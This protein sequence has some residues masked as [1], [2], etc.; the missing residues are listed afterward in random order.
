MMA[1]L[2]SLARLGADTRGAVLIETAIVMPVLV[3]MCLGA[4]EVSMMV[5]RQSELQGAAAEAAAIA[6]AAKP[7]T[8]EKID[9]VKQV[10]ETS[11][12]L[13]SGSVT[14][15]T[16]YRCQGMEGYYPDPDS[17]GTGTYAWRYLQID[18]H[19]SYAPLWTQ[20]GVDRPVEYNVRRFVMVAG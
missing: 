18:M 3:L 17:C 19:D 9:T 13:A 14:L 11:T 7:D 15:E 1:R 12:G 16:V 10:I 8:T 5:A 4:F 6:L 2:R 20:F